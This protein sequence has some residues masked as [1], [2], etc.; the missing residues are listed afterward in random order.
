MRLK[1]SL[2]SL[3]TALVVVFA[4]QTAAASKSGL[5]TRGPCYS[6]AKRMALEIQK[7]HL[8]GKN[9]S[10]PLNLVDGVF[11]MVTRVGLKPV[12]V[13]AHAQYFGH[14]NPLPM[15]Y[16]ISARA[17]TVQK[18]WSVSVG[19]STWQDGTVAY[20]FGKPV[21]DQLLAVVPIPS[22]K[23]V[24]V[25]S[26]GPN[27]YQWKKRAGIF[28]PAKLQFTHREGGKTR[29]S[30]VV[31]ADSGGGLVN[32]HSTQI[33]AVPSKGVGAITQNMNLVGRTRDGFALYELAPNALAGTVAIGN[34]T[35]TVQRP[36][37]IL[38]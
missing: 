16:F 13:S 20:N 14:M 17:K 12:E 4:L 3:T 37:P 9:Y 18:T 33:M 19:Q 35:Y 32:L 29:I 38:R 34:S 15:G 1:T 36:L 6:A 11:K 10:G 31:M 7:Y 23:R 24:V 28:D 2:L 30:D 22:A 8:Q 21:F 26:E 5:Q 25:W 27:S